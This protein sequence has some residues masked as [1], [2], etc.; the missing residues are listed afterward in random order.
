[1]TERNPSCP[2]CG[3]PA[4]RGKRTAHFRRGA[5]TVSVE[6]RHW[7]CPGGCVGSDGEQVF[8]F[9]DAILMAENTEAARAA[10]REKYGE[11][12]PAPRRPGRRTT[13]KRTERVA[14]ALSPSEKAAL[15]ARSTRGALNEHIRRYSLAAPLRSKSA[16]G[17]PLV[18]TR[19]ENGPHR[20]AS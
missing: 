18:E 11:A 1:M 9:E 13:E 12:M 2:F 5:R 16:P 15:L 20:K 14:I 4:E 7:E 17:F 3:K 10:W 19:D 6:V 8:R